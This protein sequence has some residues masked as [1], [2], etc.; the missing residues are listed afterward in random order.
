MDIPAYK[1]MHLST[2]WSITVPT[3]SGR[4]ITVAME[5]FCPAVEDNK[6]TRLERR[7]SERLVLDDV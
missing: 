2:S 1:I 5:D 7:N 6:F 4:P 3:S